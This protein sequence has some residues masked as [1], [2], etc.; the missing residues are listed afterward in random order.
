MLVIKLSISEHNIDKIFTV[1]GKQVTDMGFGDRLR[2]LRK[3]QGLTQKQLAD[4]LGVV[5][6]VVSYYESGERYPSYDVLIKISSIFHISTDYLLG[7]ERNRTIDVSGL[8][9]E[10]TDVII[11]VVNALRN[12]NK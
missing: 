2:E 5:K 7:I 11:S 12:R 10:E 1:S 8:S 6:S 4:R 3:G 9:A